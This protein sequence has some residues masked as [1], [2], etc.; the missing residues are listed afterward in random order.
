[1]EKKKIAKNILN[2]NNNYKK[3]NLG[4]SYEFNF[5][6][7]NFNS[8]F[9]YNN[10]T[11]KDMILK[12]DTK[13]QN[14]KIVIEN[15]PNENI[16]N[17]F[18]SINPTVRNKILGGLKNILTKDNN[19]QKKEMVSKIKAKFE[20]SRKKNIKDKN[21]YAT[22]IQKIF[23]GYIYRKNNEFNSENKNNA[24]FNQGVYIRKKIMNNRS[25]MNSNVNISDNKIYRRSYLKE[26]NRVKNFETNKFEYKTNNENDNKIEEIIIDKKRIFNALNP[27]T[28][29]N[30]IQEI[31]I[32]NSS[33]RNMKTLKKY[34]LTKYFN[35]WKDITKRRIII[36]NLI[37]YMKNKRKNLILNNI[38]YN[39]QRNRFRAYRRSP[40]KKNY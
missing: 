25:S 28:K 36:Q 21:Y 33:F 20:Y 3:Y 29:N 8:N 13:T 19:N 22:K 37:N 14:N 4:D 10:L 7:N 35:I 6:F 9:T 26:R 31:T 34:K 32:N 15:Y 1:M 11:E 12:N 27:S 23:R 39:Y 2:Q 5:T 18:K 38:D 24:K 40:I 16:I 30:N 17:K